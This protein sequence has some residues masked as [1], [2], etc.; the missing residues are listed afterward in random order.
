MQMHEK[1]MLKSPL[2]RRILAYMIDCALLLLI[3]ASVGGAV[4]FSLRLSFQT[5]QEVYVAILLN[6]SIPVWIYFIYADCSIRGATIGKKLFHLQTVAANGQQL[7]FWQALLRTAIKLMPWELIHIA[8]F[9]LPG[10]MGAFPTE[11]G[12][13]FGLAYLLIIIY[14]AVAWQTG[15]HK[16]VHDYAT[17]ALVRVTE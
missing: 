8:A 1:N 2:A 12:I 11:S 14:L 16:S 13:G 5:P 3:L 4:L 9:F 10:G 6:F 17:G 15:G 7:P